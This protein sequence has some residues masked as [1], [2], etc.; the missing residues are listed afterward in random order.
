MSL[1]SVDNQ[2]A[3]T[4]EQIHDAQVEKRRDALRQMI[5]MDVF[6]GR[7]G[8]DVRYDTP[9]SGFPRWPVVEASLDPQ[10]IEGDVLGTCMINRETGEIQSIRNPAFSSDPT[11]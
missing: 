7:T 1:E 8:S 3:P 4:E 9:G 10:E 5:E 6:F 11:D 2:T